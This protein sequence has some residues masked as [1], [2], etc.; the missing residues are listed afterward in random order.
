MTVEEAQEKLKSGVDI[1][2]DLFWR[3]SGISTM[4]VFQAKVY[5]NDLAKFAEKVETFTA[6]T[7]KHK[8]R[9]VH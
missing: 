7:A 4:L 3:S 5:G 1:G 6:G 2:L 8:L 9:E